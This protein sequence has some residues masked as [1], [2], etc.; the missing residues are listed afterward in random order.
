VA[1]LKSGRRFLGNDLNAEAVRLAAKRL[2]EFG[3][4]T[5]PPDTREDAPSDLIE[6]MR[7]LPSQPQV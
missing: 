3:E 7:P 1:A 6:L 2:R 5:Q 4:G